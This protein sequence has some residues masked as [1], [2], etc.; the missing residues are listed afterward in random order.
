[1]RAHSVSRMQ[2][3]ADAGHPKEA[4]E[5][6][7]QMVTLDE[8]PLNKEWLWGLGKL[9]REYL[10]MKLANCLGLYNAS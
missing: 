10:K 1:M 3:H 6:P 7:S 9:I 8:M 4:R 2:S 5:T